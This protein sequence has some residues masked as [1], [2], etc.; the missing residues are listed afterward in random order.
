M[1]RRGFLMIEMYATLALAS[2]FL[3]ISARLTY[4]IHRVMRDASQQANQT[5]QI[6]QL[7]A[8]LATD[9]WNAEQLRIADDHT[10]MLLIADGQL[11]TWRQSETG[12]MQRILTDRTHRWND[13][14]KLSFT[15]S[16]IAVQ[17]TQPGRSWT[18]PSQL[19]S[20]RRRS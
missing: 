4:S 10:L 13:L 9:V 8:I 1:K 6:E 17:L 3:L 14:P 20:S 5:A 7:R 12:E 2:A 18:F 11:I 16:D 19:L 15:T